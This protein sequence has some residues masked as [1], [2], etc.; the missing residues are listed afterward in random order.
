[1]AFLIVWLA[2]CILAGWIAAEKG[3][4]GVGFFLLAF[5]LSPV[6]GILAAFGAQPRHEAPEASPPA[7]VSVAPS[8]EAIAEQAATHSDWATLVVFGLVLIGLAAMVIWIVVSA[9]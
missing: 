6:I 7:E 8:V 9:G 2:L 5:F 3:R 4:S 1:M